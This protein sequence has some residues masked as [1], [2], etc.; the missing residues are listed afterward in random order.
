MASAPFFVHLFFRIGQRRSGI[1]DEKE[2]VVLLKVYMAALRGVVRLGDSI[3]FCF[4]MSNFIRMCIAGGIVLRYT[5]K[6][7]T[8]EQE[9]KKFHRSLALL[10]MC[11]LLLPACAQDGGEPGET[12]AAVMDTAVPAD[13]TTADPNDRS[14]VKDNVPEDL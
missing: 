10:L 7:E 3:F 9:M 13:T 12:T 11:A 5:E 14:Q 8:E 2:A 4:E 1:F 6:K